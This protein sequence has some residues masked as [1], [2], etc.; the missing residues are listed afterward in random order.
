VDV[1]DKI[2][3]KIADL[4]IYFT[5]TGASIEKTI[6]FIWDGRLVDEYKTTRSGARI[7]FTLPI[8]HIESVARHGSHLLQVYMTAVINGEVVT[9]E[10]VYKDIILFDPTRT[11]PVIGCAPQ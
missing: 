9:S 4:G 8:S 1:D 11:V 7:P 10:S 2:T 5:P 6:Y 3:H